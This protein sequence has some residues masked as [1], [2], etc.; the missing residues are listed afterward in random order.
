MAV[1]DYAKLSKFEDINYLCNIRDEK[2]FNV[3][4]VHD[5]GVIILQNC[6]TDGKLINISIYQYFT[7]IQQVLTSLIIHFSIKRCSCT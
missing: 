5:K 4:F 6:Y 3:K 2:D 7:I 1:P